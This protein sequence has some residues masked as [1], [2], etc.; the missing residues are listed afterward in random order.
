M[1]RPQLRDDKLYQYMCASWGALPFYM[2]FLGIQGILLIGQAQGFYDSWA[3][4]LAP[5]Y[6]IIVSL[7][8]HGLLLYCFSMESSNRNICLKCWD[9]LCASLM[10]ICYW[11]TFVLFIALLLGHLYQSGT[12]DWEEALLPPSALL[13]AM[14]LIKLLY[15]A[16]ICQKT[17][18]GEYVIMGYMPSRGD[19]E[20]E[21]N[22]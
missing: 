16:C 10:P 20:Q 2:L 11:L 21:D 3:G 13:V 6:V 14:S 7:P 19:S 12:V 18:D 4:T 17:P 22:A 1:G 8:I 5:S 9:F 15:M